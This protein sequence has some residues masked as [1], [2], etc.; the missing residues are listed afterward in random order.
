MQ[1]L[2]DQVRTQGRLPDQWHLDRAPRDLL[3]LVL[4]SKETFGAGAF[5]VVVPINE[6]RVLKVTTCEASN[7]ILPKLMRKPVPGL[8]IVYRDFGVVGRVS[9]IEDYYDDIPLR[10]YVMERLYPAH[11]FEQL[12]KDACPRGD[13]MRAR[14]VSDAKGA[15]AW[16]GRVVCERPAKYRH[17]WG[18]SPAAEPTHPLVCRLEASLRNTRLEPLVNS[19]RRLAPRVQAGEWR[20]DWDDYGSFERNVMLSMWGEPILSDPVYDRCQTSWREP[21][22]DRY[23][24]WS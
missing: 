16:L 12:R 2:Q 15:R 7:V 4:D 5:S 1:T 23:G 9:G 3:R 13:H 20:F 22:W 18:E 24:D 14:T 11:A 10:A 17:Q 8:P 6:A 21:Y 19:V